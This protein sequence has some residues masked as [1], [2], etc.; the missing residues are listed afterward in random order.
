M[1]I[2]MKKSIIENLLEQGFRADRQNIVR[3]QTK[4]D[5]FIALVNFR[6][7]HFFNHQNFYLTTFLVTRAANIT[8]VNS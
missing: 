4:L 7:A 1:Q 8:V 3:V 2:G 5:N 6:A